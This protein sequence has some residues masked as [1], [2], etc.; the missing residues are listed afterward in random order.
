MKSRRSILAALAAAPVAIAVPAAARPVVTRWHQL[1]RRA[2]RL[3]RYSKVTSGRAP[4][5]RV[6]NRDIQRLTELVADITDQLVAEHT[7]PR[8]AGPQLALE[9]LSHNPA[10]AGAHLPAGVIHRGGAS[11]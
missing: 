4:S 5:R 6:L 7:T 11:A 10:A 8:D 9:S 1:Q 3:A 2:Q